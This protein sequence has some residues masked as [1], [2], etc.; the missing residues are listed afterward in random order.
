MAVANVYFGARLQVASRQ[1][2]SPLHP[3]SNG[4]SGRN[5]LRSFWNRL[6]YK[7]NISCKNTFFLFFS[8]LFFPF[9]LSLAILIFNTDT[10]IVASPLV[11]GLARPMLLTLPLP[12]M[13]RIIRFLIMRQSQAAR[14]AGLPSHVPTK[15]RGQPTA[16]SPMALQQLQSAVAPKPAGAVPATP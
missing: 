12:A 3:E 15:P 8:F 14:A 2:E 16:L 9:F 7:V 10:G 6:I 4:H 13:S 5:R 11:L 1:D